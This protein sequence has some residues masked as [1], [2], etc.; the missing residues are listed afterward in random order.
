[1]TPSQRIR[2]P[3]QLI[4]FLKS[5]GISLTVKDGRL[6]AAPRSA[7]TPD[8][9][10]VLKEWKP[11]LL[12]VVPLQDSP[13][14]N[15]PADAPFKRIRRGQPVA[16][17]STPPDWVGKDKQTAPAGPPA[18]C[19]M[20]AGTEFYERRARPA[21]KPEYICQ[22]CHPRADQPRTARKDQVAA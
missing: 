7:V 22:Q 8:V 16:S 18:K 20:C 17:Y 1:L 5:Q 14:W 9:A 12:T 19:R 10:D 13:L 4:E 11:E 15:L 3:R 21:G 2:Y 6:I